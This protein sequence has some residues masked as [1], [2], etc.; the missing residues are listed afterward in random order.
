MDP[1]RRPVLNDAALSLAQRGVWALCI[2]VYLTVFVGGITAGGAD[3]LVMG[4]AIAFTLVTAF[5]GHIALG[6]LARASLPV[7]E[8]PL[9]KPEGPVG[10]LVDVVSSTNVAGQEDG[11]EAA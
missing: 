5:L 9:A 1:T 2:G 8:G 11:A 3:L 6:L 10:S 7:E 4:R